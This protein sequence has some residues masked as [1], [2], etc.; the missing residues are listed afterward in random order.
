MALDA[1][2]QANLMA[3]CKIDDPIDPA[4]AELLAECYH[5]AVDYMDGAGVRLPSEGTPRHAKY[6]LCIKPLVLDMW[7]NRGTQIAGATTTDNVTFQR[8]KNQLKYT[9]PVSELD[10]GSSS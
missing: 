10:T 8:I 7:D 9:E 1:K 4:D 6:M 2:L 3:Y 5:A